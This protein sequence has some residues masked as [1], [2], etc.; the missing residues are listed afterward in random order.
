MKKPP[1]D[2]PS[3]RAELLALADAADRGIDMRRLEG[4]MI[5]ARDAGMLWRDILRE[6]SRMLVLGEDLH[7]LA[8]AFDAWRKAHPQRRPA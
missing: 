6:V 8:N 3:L 1:P 5:G 7:D 2:L 4:L